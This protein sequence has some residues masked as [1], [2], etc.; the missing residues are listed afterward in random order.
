[1]NAKF[2]LKS[3][4]FKYH[5][6]LPIKPAIPSDFCPNL[7]FPKTFVNEVECWKNWC[8]AIKFTLRNHC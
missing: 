6:K 5:P 8:I 7:V 2:D 3:T 4:H 1:M